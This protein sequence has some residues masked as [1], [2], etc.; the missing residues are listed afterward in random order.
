VALA[1]LAQLRI[2]QAL[3]NFQSRITL[4]AE[5]WRTSAVSSTLNPPKKRSSIIL[6]FRTSNSA[7]AF[8]ASSSAVRFCLKLLKHDPQMKLAQRPKR[9]CRLR[10]TIQSGGDGDHYWKFARGAV[11]CPS[12]WG[13]GSDWNT[14]HP[15]NHGKRLLW[16]AFGFPFETPVASGARSA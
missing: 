7:R 13:T 3:A 6:A 11:G 4:C 1:R 2:S 14:R 9:A 5:I 12:S 15:E 8:K 10:V 16:M